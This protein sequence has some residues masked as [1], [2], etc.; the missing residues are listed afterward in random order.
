MTDLEETATVR[1]ALAACAKTL[2]GKSAAGSTLS[3]SETQYL[4]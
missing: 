3:R 2:A 4:A 1:L